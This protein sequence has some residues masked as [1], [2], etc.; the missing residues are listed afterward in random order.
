[1]LVGAFEIHPLVGAAIDLAVDA[2][3]TG[4]V[5]RVSRT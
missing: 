2:G 3:E 5:H 4:E 1:M